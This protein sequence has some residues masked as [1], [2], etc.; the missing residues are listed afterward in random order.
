M[1]ALRFCWLALL[2][3]LGS[4]TTEKVV[5]EVGH[6]GEARRN[7]FLAVQRFMEARDYDVHNIVRFSDEVYPG[8][9][10]VTPAQS[11][12]NYGMTDV[13]MKWVRRGG[14]LVVFL[15]HGEAF[16]NDWMP[17]TIRDL[18][19]PEDEQ[20][21]LLE[22]LG[23]AEVQDSSSSVKGEVLGRQVEYE[24]HASFTWRAG[25]K[26]RLGFFVG[27]ANRPA[28][29]SFN[30]GNGHV[31]IIASAKP[32]RN[33]Y[34][35][36]GDHAWIF[37]LLTAH[38]ETSGMFFLQGVRVSF[39]SML[40]EHG[41][42]AIV[43]VLLLIGFWLWRHLP[44]F[45]PLHRYVERVSRDF[46]A[47]LGVIGAFLWKHKQQRSLLEPLREAILRA[48]S[49]R[50]ILSSSPEFLEKLGAIA[51]LPPERVRVILDAE[52]GDPQFFVHTVQDLQELAT[53]LRA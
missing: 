32:F 28:A 39:F 6:V 44:R 4:C 2:L 5:T 22:K 13:V 16:R 21:V 20:A 14:H 50:G 51:A 10:L 35:G 23:V 7:P 12:V 47:H 45:G 15:R 8:G 48:A 26:P 11:F 30:H 41:W 49:R 27:D 36:N 42:M 40:W 53:A 24:P 46:A 29:A 52:P 9:T 33:R 3:L 37:W 1:K 17:F 31:T 25:E 19:K 34:V 43:P 38:E 18:E